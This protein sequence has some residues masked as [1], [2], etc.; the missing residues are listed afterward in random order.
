MSEEIK[1]E[2]MDDKRKELLMNLCDA[3]Y[4]C[5]DDSL[6]DPVNKFTEASKSDHCACY[7]NM[8]AMKNMIRDHPEKFKYYLHIIKIHV[9]EK[10]CEH[11]WHYKKYIKALREYNKPREFE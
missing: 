10:I 6:N 9:D 4:E 2:H 11:V 8:I 3:I 1:I 7:G 5:M